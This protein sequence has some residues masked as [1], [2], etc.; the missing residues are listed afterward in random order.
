V[1]APTLEVKLEIGS[2]GTAFVFKT[3]DLSDLSQ[4]SASST[5][6]SVRW[7]GAH[8]GLQTDRP[9]SSVRAV[10]GIVDVDNMTAFAPSATEL[11]LGSVELVP[12]ARVLSPFST[13]TNITVPI[14]ARVFTLLVVCRNGASSSTNSM[15]INSISVE[16]VGEFVFT[17]AVVS[18]PRDANTPNRRGEVMPATKVIES[19]TPNTTP[20][21]ILSPAATSVWPP[22]SSMSLEPTVDGT[23]ASLA[24]TNTTTQGIFDA[25]T[26]THGNNF[27]LIGGVVGRLD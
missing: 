26:D 23:S 25:T 6:V 1:G 7:S 20:P 11:P 21:P 27:A 13:I 14:N 8:A 10:A 17:S 18:A 12:S 19:S 4:T 2:Y 3:F 9:M 16:H 5:L 24:N 22:M 15:Q